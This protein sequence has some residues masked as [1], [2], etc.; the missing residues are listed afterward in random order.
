M[1]GTPTAALRLPHWGRQVGLICSH[2]RPGNITLDDEPDLEIFASA[3]MLTVV[4][5]FA[6]PCLLTIVSPL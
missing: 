2:T 1:S 3:F 5:D 4:S 6:S